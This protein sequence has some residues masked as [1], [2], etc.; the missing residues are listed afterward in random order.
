[1]L[2]L[3]HVTFEACS[4][5]KTK[6]KERKLYYLVEYICQFKHNFNNYC[7]YCLY[8]SQSGFKLYKIYLYFQ[9]LLFF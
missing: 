5:Y 6:K 2:P 7:Y 3:K 8:L 9:G 1:M 4:W